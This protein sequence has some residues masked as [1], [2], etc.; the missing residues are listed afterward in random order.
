MGRGVLDSI[1]YGGIFGTCWNMGH[2]LISDH[3]AIRSLQGTPAESTKRGAAAQKERNA[4]G[5]NYSIIPSRQH[6]GPICARIP[7]GEATLY[8]GRTTRFMLSVF[9]RGA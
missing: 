3:A 7:D 1:S 4:E 5:I 8:T 2:S 6:F 9:D